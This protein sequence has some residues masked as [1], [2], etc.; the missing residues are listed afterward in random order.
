MKTTWSVLLM[1]SV[2]LMSACGG[3]GEPTTAATPNTAAAPQEDWSLSAAP[4]VPPIAVDESAI[5]ASK[6]E[7][8]AVVAQLTEFRRTGTSLT[9]RIVLRNEGVEWQKPTFIFRDVHLLD[10]MT[11]TRYDVLKQPNDTYVASANRLFQDRFSTDLDPG[12]SVAAWMTFAAPPPEVKIVAL[13]IPNIEPF[14]H[15][16]IQ[17]P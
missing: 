4:P 13:K 9:A 7:W 1:A 14:E 10:R 6:T 2:G 15:L 11:G 3:R 12:Q 5:A 17:D 16:S 8:P